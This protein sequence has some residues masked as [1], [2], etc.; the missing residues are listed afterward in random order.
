M[1]I[2]HFNEDGLFEPKE[3]T[4]NKLSY[5]FDRWQDEMEYK[6]WNDYEDAIRKHFAAHYGHIRVLKV[7]YRNGELRILFKD[8]TTP[9]THKLIMNENE[10]RVFN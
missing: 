5:Y 4:R 8:G 2:P 9:R 3:E 6:D 10:I 1:T 7:I